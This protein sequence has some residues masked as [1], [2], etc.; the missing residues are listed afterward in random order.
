MRIN[1]ASLL[2]FSFSCFLVDGLFFHAF[3]S[4][5]YLSRYKMPLA[6]LGLV[7][8]LAVWELLWFAFDSWDPEERFPGIRF[9]FVRIA[10]MGKTILDL[11][12]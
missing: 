10:Q 4:L 1:Y 12:S 6:L 9:A 7:I 5:I 11:I 2:L 8:S 3:L